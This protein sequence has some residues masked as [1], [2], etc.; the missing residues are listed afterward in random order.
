MALTYLQS[1]RLEKLSD[2]SKVAL[3]AWKFKGWVVIRDDCG[4]LME[5]GL[6]DI[7]RFPNVSSG[8]RKVQLS[9]WGKAIKA[10][11]ETLP[12]PPEAP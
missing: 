10:H 8:I 7:R 12:T 6:L 11:L 4:P 2:K 9:Q 5:A 1:L 3:L